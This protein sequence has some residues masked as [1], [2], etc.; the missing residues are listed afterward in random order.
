M[1][2][3]IGRRIGGNRPASALRPPR[4]SL[5]LMVVLPLVLA[6]AATLLGWWQARAQEPVSFL[7][8]DLVVPADGTADD[9]AVRPT[10]MCVY[11][12]E[13]AATVTVSR[14]PL[15]AEAGGGHPLWMTISPYASTAFPLIEKANVMGSM[16]LTIPELGYE[17]CFSF[18]N[19]VYP[20]EAQEVAQAYKYFAQVVSIEVR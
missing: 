9:N 3:D 16:T 11:L 15:V 1:N 6:P 18:E 20:R 2:T 17:T 14:R 13:E 19:R 8:V 7:R 10:G 5:V 4:F 12:P